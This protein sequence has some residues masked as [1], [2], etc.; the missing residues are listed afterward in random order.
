MKATIINLFQKVGRASLAIGLQN[1]HSGNMACLISAKDKPVQLVITKSGAQ[2]GDLEPE[3]ILFMEMAKEKKP[4]ASSE[5]IVHRAILKLPEAQASLHAHAKN[6]TL[7]TLAF[8]AKRKKSLSFSPLDPLGI[9]Y[10]TSIPIINVKKAYG[11]LELAREV[12]SGLKNYPVVAIRG[13]GL[14]ARGR[15]LLEAFFYA[16]IADFSAQVWKSLKSLRIPEEKI[17]E[18]KR[19]G[20]RELF[21]PPFPYCLSWER[22]SSVFLN[23]N[24]LKIVEKTRNRLFL[25]QISPFFTGSL[26]WKNRKKIIYASPAS[27]P[28]EIKGPL[29]AFDLSSSPEDEEFFCHRLIYEQTPAQAIIRAFIAEAEAIA[30]NLSFLNDQLSY[31]KPLDVEGKVLHPQ[32]PVFLPPIDT[33]VFL[34]LLK[35]HQLVIVRGGGVWAISSLSLSKALHHL[36]SLRDSLHYFLS[37]KELN[38]I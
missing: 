9:I 12:A 29:K 25:S 22:K 7:M 24:E 15:T 18:E 27:T 31:F 19:K 5:L 3:D 6:V 28:L 16:G 21:F 2:K 4:E 26:S 1:S 37:L 13:H 36:S 20:I 10:L 35:K 17:D 23:K 34:E 11:S 8:S 14:F 38:L 32:V 33:A 30:W